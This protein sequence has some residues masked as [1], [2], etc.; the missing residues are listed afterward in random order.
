MDNK[1]LYFRSV[2]STYMRS[3]MRERII[4]GVK[5][6]KRDYR[7]LH[8]FD[9]HL[10]RVNCSNPHI[11]EDI[12]SDWFS[13]FPDATATTM[14]EKRSTA[15]RF[16][17]YLCEIGIECV[18]PRV[19][20]MPPSGYIPHVFTHEEIRIL[21]E[22]SNTLSL[23]NTFPKSPLISFPTIIRVLYSTGIRIGEAIGLL[24]ADVN[25]D[26][27]H[28]IVRQ[29]KNN[30]Q[31]IAPIN[32]SLEKVL[33]Q[34]L[35]YRNLIIRD[36]IDSPD[37]PFFVTSTGD[38]I[39]PRSLSDWFSKL[40]DLSGICRD[41]LN[42]GYGIHTLRHTACV[43]SMM[44]LHSEGMDMYAYLPAISKFMGHLHISDTERYLRQTV[45]MYPE[46]A[47]IDKE[48]SKNIIK[49]IVE[50]DEK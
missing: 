32:E 17:R 46:L 50:S 42:T 49:P 41:N 29:T 11:T 45:E 30:H 4:C 14:H 37:S 26:N 39:K 19:P 22:R 9:D 1:K 15:A 21:F 16:A 48:I 27:H 7:M 23:M 5:N 20:K 8:Q 36:D 25:L 18:I 40:L 44:K 6:L 34:Y 2:L 31:R 24:N 43:H 12:W 10:V 35:S 28:I 47:S 38:K 13:S 3:Y 33:R